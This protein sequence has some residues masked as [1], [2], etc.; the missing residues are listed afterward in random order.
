M[1]V[2]CLKTKFKL[3]LSC[4]VSLFPCLFSKVFYFSVTRALCTVPHS[5]DRAKRSLN[6]VSNL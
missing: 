6:V 2:K 5:Q 1:K 3:D 4:L